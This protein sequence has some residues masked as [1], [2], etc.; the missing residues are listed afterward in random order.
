MKIQINVLRAAINKMLDHV[1]ELEGAEPSLA[2]DLYWFVP[3]E[4]LGDP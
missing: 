2:T 1:Q 4:I 3:S